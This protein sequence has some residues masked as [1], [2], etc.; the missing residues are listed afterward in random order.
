VSRGARSAQT[1]KVLSKQRAGTVA[2]GPAKRRNTWW[3]KHERALAPYLFL[4]PFALLFVVVLLGPFGFAAWLS[5][6]EWNGFGSFEPKGMTNY[7]E[8][9]GSPE[10][11]AAVGNSLIFAVCILVS[12]IP[13]SLLLAVAL[14][15]RRLRGRTLLRS[16]FVAPT[17]VST[18]AV[19]VVF[20][21]VFD[22]RYGLVNAG[23]IRVFGGDGI[24]WIG[25]A[26]PARVSIMLVVFWRSLG[27]T[28]LFFLAGLQ[29][30]SQ[31]QI[32]AA[33]VDGANGRQVFRHVTL[34]GLRPMTAFVTVVGIISMLQLFEEPFLLTNGGPAGST[35][36]IVQLS[37]EAAFVDGRF[38]Y[39]ASIGVVLVVAILVGAAVLALVSRLRS[40]VERQRLRPEASHGRVAKT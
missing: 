2:A 28:V 12:L 32:D 9:F 5:L 25:E 26:W 23:L 20:I 7:R 21:L 29:N 36:T 16:V 37:Y 4:T 11:R 17:A 40:A 22:P 3:S 13:A 19:A 34:P 15:A 10:F 38:G 30:I 14:H 39:A 8:L 1:P 31:E 35:Q 6:H 33:R 27:L 18:A 24:D